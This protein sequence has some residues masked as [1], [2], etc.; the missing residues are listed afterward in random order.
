MLISHVGYE[1]SPS[2]TF[3]SQSLKQKL[4]L[5]IFSNKQLPRW[6]WRWGCSSSRQD[7]AITT[8]IDGHNDRQFFC[9]GQLSVL[10]RS[11]ATAERYGLLTNFIE[12]IAECYPSVNQK[13]AYMPFLLLIH[14]HSHH[15]QCASHR[16]KRGREPTD[17]I[18]TC[19]TVL[20]GRFCNN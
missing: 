13:R 2:W 14:A 7:S 10:G 1:D 5:P 3:F 19:L 11:A 15:Y 20:P 16:E 9:A 17:Y 8:L 4:G 12:A 6:F 18:P